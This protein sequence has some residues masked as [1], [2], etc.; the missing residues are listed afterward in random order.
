M[1]PAKELI[2]TVGLPFSGKSSYVKKLAAENWQVV[3]RDQLLEELLQSSEYQQAVVDRT[4]AEGAITPEAVFAI[5]NKIAVSMLGEKARAVIR[6]SAANKI[7]FD[8]T[9]LQRRMR[10]ELLQLRSEGIRVEA[11]VFNVPAE[12][13]VE[14][15]QRAWDA[16]ERDG[17]FNRGAFGNLVRMAQ[18]IEDITPDEGFDSI[19]IIAPTEKEEVRNERRELKLN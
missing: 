19:E 2:C 6:D 4:Q 14:R 16:G 11:A 8:G 17:S 3:S 15:A 10:A 9:N 5:K 12:K 18:M 13:I 1:P 7:V